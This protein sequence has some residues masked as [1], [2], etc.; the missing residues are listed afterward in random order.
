MIFINVMVLKNSVSVTGIP[1]YYR[2]RCSTLKMTQLSDTN[3]RQL[4]MKVAKFLHLGKEY[5]SLPDVSEIIDIADFCCLY[6]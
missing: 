3:D 4:L 1:R 2:T 5:T 6:T